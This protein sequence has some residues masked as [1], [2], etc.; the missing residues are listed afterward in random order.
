MKK[1]TRSLLGPKPLH[2]VNAINT[3]IRRTFRRFRLLARMQTH[4]IQRSASQAVNAA[5]A[6]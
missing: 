3:D 6:V 5:G 4:S 2:Y 1:P